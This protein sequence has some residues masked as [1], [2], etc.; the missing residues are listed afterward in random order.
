MAFSAHI[1]R[2]EHVDRVV[3]F[4]VTTPSQEPERPMVRTPSLISRWKTSAS[5]PLAMV[6]VM[7]GPFV[8]DRVELHWPSHLQQSQR[9]VLRGVAQ[10]SLTT[11]EEAFL[12]LLLSGS[13]GRGAGTVRSDLDVYVILDST[14]D[15]AR[16]PMRSPSLDE[17]PLRIDELEQVPP[18]GTAGW[19]FRWS[20]AWAPVLL[21]RTGGR[22]SRAAR[23]Q[24]TLTPAEVDDVLFTHGRLDGWTNFFYRALK[25]D[26]DGHP[27]ACRLDSAE[28]VPWLLDVV[29]AFEGR[30][31]PYNKYLAW[32]L[33][34]HPL[35]RWLGADL[36]PLIGRLLDGDPQALRT[37]F[38]GIQRTGRAFD[39]SHGDE[40][41][42]TVLSEWSS[43]L[44][45]LL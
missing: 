10:R 16:S 6:R 28:S 3:D 20:Y 22:I 27:D 9:A 5:T 41:V 14:T 15:Q 30:V 44:D 21:D 13:A 43:D 33:Q 34:T 31:R 29:F 36:L 26:R 11:F 40:R 39:T 7:D 1:I 45:G 38:I 37:A 18:F 12:G 42:R 2:D 4:A 8:P 25:S 23:R 17:L 35:H 24:A 32:E 19:W